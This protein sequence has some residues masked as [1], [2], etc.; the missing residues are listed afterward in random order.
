MPIYLK[1]VKRGARPPRARRNMAIHFDPTT[2]RMTFDTPEEALAFIRKSGKQASA[3][4]RKRRRARKP[5]AEPSATVSAL[6]KKAAGKKGGRKRRQTSPDPYVKIA[7]AIG[8]WPVMVLMCPSIQQYK[9]Q[10]Y[11]QALQSMGLSE[12]DAQAVVDLMDE[13]R[14]RLPGGRGD[15]AAQAWNRR[16]LQ[17]AGISCPT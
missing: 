13:A 9:T 1:H 10:R 5:A 16:I 17:S 14:T 2:G 11:R 4:D 15:A 7:K 3:P 6:R 8:G 12:D